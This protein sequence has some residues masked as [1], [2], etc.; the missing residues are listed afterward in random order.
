MAIG[1]PLSLEVVIFCTLRT[2]QPRV[3]LKREACSTSE[4][5]TTSSPSSRV[6]SSPLLHLNSPVLTLCPGHFP[7]LQGFPSLHPLVLSSHPSKPCSLG[8]NQ[9]TNSRHLARQHICMLTGI[10]LGK[11]PIGN[12]PIHSF[13]M[14]FVSTYSR[15]GTGNTQ[16][17]LPHVDA[18]QGWSLAEAGW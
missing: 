11:S 17:A 2:S 8:G 1:P 12:K 16:R 18:L 3:K 5:R 14:Y 15:P 7:E 10:F 13:N 6:F 4:T 9:E